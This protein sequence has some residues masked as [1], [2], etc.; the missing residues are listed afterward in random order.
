MHVYRIRVS[1]R[2]GDVTLGGRRRVGARAT[3]KIDLR[4]S[5]VIGC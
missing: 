5:S 1:P 4:Q 3:E 2:V